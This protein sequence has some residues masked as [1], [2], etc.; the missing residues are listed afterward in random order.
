MIRLMV[1]LIAVIS[2]LGYNTYTSI[3]KGDNKGA[4]VR[5]NIIYLCILYIIFIILP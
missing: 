4:I 5:D 3:Y 2:I 1:F